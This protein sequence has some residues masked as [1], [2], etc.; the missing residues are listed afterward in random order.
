MYAVGY[1]EGSL[2]WDLM[3]DYYRNFYQDLMGNYTDE[4]VQPVLDFVNENDQ[5]VI[6]EI[7]VY[8]MSF[9][10]H[11]PATKTTGPILV[12]HRS[13]LFPTSRPC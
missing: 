4:Q 7:Q 10:T 3:W 11:M 1:L 12:F 5:W 9:L 6:N 8:L 13:T 2:T